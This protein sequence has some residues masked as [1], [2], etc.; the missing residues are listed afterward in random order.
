MACGQTP[1]VI[2]E[3]GGRNALCI[4]SDGSYGSSYLKLPAGI[5][6]NVSDD[7]GMCITFWMNLGKEIGAW[8]RIFDFGRSDMGP[9]I[10]LTRN[11]RASC[12]AGSDL[13]ADPGRAFPVNT[14]MHVAVSVTGTKNGTLS[15]AGPVL[16]VNGTV[17]ADGSISQTSSGNYKRLREWFAGLAK[18]GN[19]DN[20]YI[21]HSQFKADPD[22]NVSI[23]DFRVYNR[24][25]SEHEIV[26]IV[27]E[28]ISDEEVLKIVDENFLFK[29]DKIITEDIELPSSYMGGKVS[30][31]WESENEEMLSSDGR[32]G[33]F[34][35]PG[36]IKLTATLSM[37][38]SELKSST[39][40]NVIP[41]IIAPYTMTIHADKETVDISKTLYGLFYED[42][43]NAADGGLYAELLCNRSFEA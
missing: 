16:Y 11:L 22:A 5:L 37:G 32:L 29:P 40:V 31:N 39:Y 1:P 17:I 35:E 41:R 13:P 18:E 12:F 30:V 9:Y 24:V 7:D 28:T 2:E 14:W 27:C 3:I 43:N 19:Y 38:D 33:E 36:Y 4:K 20:N 8:E 26:D 34:T 6:D 42:I 10:F 15:S 25:L 23:S 21:G